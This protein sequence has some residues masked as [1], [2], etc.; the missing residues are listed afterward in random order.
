MIMKVEKSDAEIVEECLRRMV[1]RYLTATRGCLIEPA[2]LSESLMPGLYA[3]VI[4]LVERPVIE[5]VLFHCSNNQSDAARV[6]GLNR[7]TLR[8]KMKKYGLL[9]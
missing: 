3:Q 2:D 5:E 6:I 9:P 4:H 1:T 8:A 7:G